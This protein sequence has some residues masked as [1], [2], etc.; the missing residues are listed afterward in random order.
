MIIQYSS[1]G[2]SVQRCSL[3]V[4]TIRSPRCI[5]SC[6]QRAYS[7]SSSSQSRGGSQ[8]DQENGRGGAQNG[9]LMS[10][11]GAH[12]GGFH[13]GELGKA[14]GGTCEMRG[15]GQGRLG[16]RIRG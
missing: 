8:A 2:L 7:G 15:N 1:T 16:V 12:S 13:A 14:G 6:V 4:G 3:N 11:D 9:E 5:I 10:D